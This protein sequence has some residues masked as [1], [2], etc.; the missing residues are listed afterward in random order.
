[1]ALIACGGQSPKPD[2]KPVPLPDNPVFREAGSRVISGEQLERLLRVRAGN[3]RNLWVDLG[4]EA[5]RVIIRGTVCQNRAVLEEFLCLA[6][7]KEHESIVAADIDPRTLHAALLLAGAEPGSVAKFD[8]KFHPPTGDVIEISIECKQ[9]KNGKRAKA[10]DWIRD[11]ATGKSIEHQFVFAGS[12]EI[13]HPV[14]GET[15]YLGN[16]GDIIS[17]ANF[18]SSVIDIAAES[19]ESDTQRLYE[20]FTERIPPL[21]TEVFVILKPL[22][23]KGKSKAAEPSQG[24]S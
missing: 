2:A 9:G 5:R 20:T 11:V 3:G 12:Q 14:T 6:Q 7:T 13:K 19:S 17:V 1:V 8:E 23:K 21:E 4:K 15:Y 18:A 22:P 10:Q 16:D 24:G